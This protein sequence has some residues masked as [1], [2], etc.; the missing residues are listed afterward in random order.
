MRGRQPTQDE[1]EYVM[2]VFTIDAGVITPGATMDPFTL[3]GGVTI[4]AIIEV[5]L[6]FW[7]VWAL[8]FYIAFFVGAREDREDEARRPYMKRLL[9]R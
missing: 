7:P 2:K 6:S 4:A 9:R 3:A 1:G 5:F 8:I